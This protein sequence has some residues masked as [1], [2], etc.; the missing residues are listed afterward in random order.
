MEMKTQVKSALR[1]LILPNEMDR[2]YMSYVKKFDSLKDK[3]H[4][5][6][7]QR[8]IALLAYNGG[9]MLID[10]LLVALSW[11]DD[12]TGSDTEAY[13]E[14]A[15][16]PSWIVRFCSHLVEIDENLGVIRFIHISTSVFFQTYQPNIF[17]LRVAELCLSFLRSKEFCEG[18]RVDATWYNLGTLGPILRNHPFL[19]FA[20]SQ[21]ATSLKEA[22][23]GLTNA[24]LP[25]PISSIFYR[26]SLT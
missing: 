1:D 22:T 8:T 10:V 7:A 16:D 26:L 5:Q 18:P 2:L 4:K 3:I 9:L 12:L 25:T 19:S 17:N 11:D 13:R 20:S 24:P 21:W 6:I 14:L 23:L 15:E